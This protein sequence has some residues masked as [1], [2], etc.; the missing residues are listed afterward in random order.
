MP[1]VLD[2][3]LHYSCHHCIPHRP[4]K[5]PILQKFLLPQMLLQPRILSKQLTGRNTF[6]NP[7]QLGNRIPGRKIQKNMH[8]LLRHFQFD[9]FKT[10]ILRN[11]AQHL[12][13]ASSDILPNDPSPIF[14][15]PYQMIFRVVNRM[16]GPFNGHEPMVSQ[17]G[18][19]SGRLNFSSPLK[20]RGF[21]VRFSKVGLKGRVLLERW[22]FADLAHG[23]TI[24]LPQ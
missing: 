5:I 12:F 15:C 6:Q 4:N 19:A 17:P 20:E 1:M 2:I 22:D 24:L 11:L 21:Q 7:H 14:R 16:A 13:N 23:I 8:V 3:S 10:K 18:S 9:Q